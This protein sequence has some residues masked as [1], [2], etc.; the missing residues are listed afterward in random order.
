MV[1]SRCRQAGHNIRTCPLVE[2]PSTPEHINAPSPPHA[3]NP[4]NAA[5]GVMPLILGM[6]PLGLA[7]KTQIIQII[8]LIMMVIL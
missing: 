3:P 8:T 6:Q 2:P 7:M 1:C 4:R 5:L